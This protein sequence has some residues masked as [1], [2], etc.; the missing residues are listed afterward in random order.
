MG[1][2]NVVRV[3]T[4]GSLCA[5]VLYVPVLALSQ[6]VDVVYDGVGGATSLESLRCVKFGARYLV[7]GW[8]STPNVARG[9][10]QRGA[11]NA[12]MLPTNLIMMKGLEVSASPRHA[13]CSVGH[14]C[15]VAGAAPHPHV[16]WVG[17]PLSN[18]SHL[19][20]APPSPLLCG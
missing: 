12:N 4:C 6:G 18:V 15:G 7:V 20:H 3:L 10:G 13:A 9:K 1:A 5:L 11:P 16:A 2:P 14:A 17:P 19:S 8:A